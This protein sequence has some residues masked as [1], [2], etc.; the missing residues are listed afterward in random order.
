MNKIMPTVNQN[1]FKGSFVANLKAK[2]R[3]SEGIED[4]FKPKLSYPDDVVWQ[5]TIQ[6][7]PEKLQLRFRGKDQSASNDIENA[8]A[9]YEAFPALTEAQASDQRLWTYLAHVTLRDY[10][11]ARWP[12]AGTPGQFM[13][14]QRAKGVALRSIFWHWF[15][16]GNDRTLRRNAIS[17]LWWAVHL[18]RA[19]WEKDH[20]FEDLATGDPYRFTRILLSSQDIYS[21]VLERAFGRDNRLLITI[22]EFLEENPEMHR[23]QIRAF[24]KELNLELSVKN[25][26]VLSRN[27]LKAI[28]ATI[29]DAALKNLSALEEDFDETEEEL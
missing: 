21:Q 3:N 5:S 28:V 17:R 23:N 22:L 24:M 7:D 1:I 9:I 14:D 11:M 20:S 19:P 27:A 29:G 12:L 15:A 10:V 2:L 6:V 18:T 16:S 4:Y 25:F 26:G 8:I 13:K